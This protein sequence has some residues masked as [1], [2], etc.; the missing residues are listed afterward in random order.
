LPPLRHALGCPCQMRPGRRSPRPCWRSTQRW[1]ST[2]SRG[3]ASTPCW[4]ALRSSTST[5]A[6]AGSSLL[7][8]SRAIVLRQCRAFASWRARLAYLCVKPALRRSAKQRCRAGRHC[9]LSRSARA[10]SAWARGSAPQA[11]RCSTTRMQRCGAA[12]AVPLVQ[13]AS[14]QHCLHRR[15]DVQHTTVRARR[16]VSC[17]WYDTL[18]HTSWRVEP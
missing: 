16:G 7:P 14:C 1:A 11:V 6:G 12:S 17:R 3:P 15:T 10:Q 2:A 18:S 9:A 8:V 5:A 13:Q 4:Q